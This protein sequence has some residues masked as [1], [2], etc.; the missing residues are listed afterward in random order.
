MSKVVK[1][2][3]TGRYPNYSQRNGYY[4]D[5]SDR[6]VDELIVLKQTDTQ[7]TPKNMK[8]DIVYKYFTVQKVDVIPKDLYS[9][10]MNALK[11]VNATNVSLEGMELPTCL[12]T[13][14]VIDKYSDKEDKGM[15]KLGERFVGADGKVLEVKDDLVKMPEG[16]MGVK[17]QWSVN[18]GNKVLDVLDREPS[19]SE[20][21]FIMLK[22]NV[23]KVQIVE[24]YALKM[25]QTYQ[26]IYGV[27][28]CGGKEYCWVNDNN[29]NI[30]VGDMIRVESSGDDSIVQV[31]RVENSYERKEVKR[32]IGKCLC[33]M[34]NK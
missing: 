8:R 27:F 23:N 28:E 33:S 9:D 14:K 25:A 34:F 13:Q 1:I 31:V 11:W 26:Y 24:E 16:V 5:V 29:L 32:V 30:G 10:I 15:I 12:E 17:K 19:E 4:L 18:A 22:N 3:S 2:E 7:L 21:Q 6:G 20:L